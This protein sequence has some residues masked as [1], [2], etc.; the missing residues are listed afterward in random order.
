M[1]DP[2]SEPRGQSVAKIILQQL[3]GTGRLTAMIGAHSFV[4]QSHGVQFKFKAR[5]QDGINAVVVSLFPSD[6]YRGELYRIRARQAK[7]VASYD[8]VYA[9]SLRH[10]IESRTGLA[11]SL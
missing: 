8:D 6:T 1:R 4:S 10:V 5:A 3:G 9:E 2:F 11:L 7:L